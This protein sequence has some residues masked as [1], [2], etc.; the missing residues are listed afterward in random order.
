MEDYYSVLGVSKTA[1][2]D[3]IKQAYRKLAN[4]HHPD[5]G[6]DTEQ[7]QRI[8]VAYSVLNDPQRR[9]EY[10]SNPAGNDWMKW[11][12]GFNTGNMEDFF[13]HMF[14]A[15]AP[16]DPFGFF[17]GRQQQMRNRSLNLTTQ[18]TLE[19]AYHGKNLIADVQLPSGRSQTINIKIPPGISAGQVLRLA[20]LGD[21]SVPN[22]PRGDIHLTIDVLPHPEFV[23]QGDDLIKP[24]K[25][26]CIDAITGCKLNVN[27]IDGRQ[28]E[29]VIHPG[30]QHDQTLSAQGYGM[31][32]V[33][34]PLLKGRLLMPIKIDIPI[35]LSQ[36]QA[37]ML[38]KFHQ[39]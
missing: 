19:E 35:T 37:E 12:Q 4:Q 33:N 21:D 34:N 39:L 9:Q 16:P 8:Q 32:N 28:L 3:E 1:S 24:I 5:K 14:S 10:D 29:V 36:G 17:R 27:T 30:I 6:G 20:D 23:R 7:F 2:Y 13:A 11:Q 25:V 38:S 18:I 31:P 15:G 22:I 26:M